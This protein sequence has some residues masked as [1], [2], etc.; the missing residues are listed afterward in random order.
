ME[1]SAQPLGSVLVP[2]YEGRHW[3][4]ENLYRCFDHQTYPSKELIVLDT[5]LF[6]FSDVAGLWAEFA[7]FGTSELIGVATEQCPSYQEVTSTN[8]TRIHTNPLD[9]YTRRSVSGAGLL[10]SAAGNNV[11][12]DDKSKQTMYPN[13]CSCRSNSSKNSN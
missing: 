1:E 13:D 5:D 2:T 7:H 6:L 8:S 10:T 12:G 9:S 11:L 3:A 4:H